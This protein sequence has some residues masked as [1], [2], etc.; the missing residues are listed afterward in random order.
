MDEPALR[1]D[2][3]S[4][5]VDETE[6]FMSQRQLPCTAL[7]KVR[8]ERGSLVVSALGMSFLVVP[9]RPESSQ[10]L[11]AR[12]WDDLVETETVGEDADRWLSE[13]LGVRCKLVHLLDGSIRPVNPAYGESGDRVGLAQCFPFLLVSEGSL[14]DLNTWLARHLPMNCLRPNLVVRGCN[15]LTEDGWRLV[16]IGPITLRVVKPCAR[17]AITTVNQRTSV[18]AKNF[19]AIWPDFAESEPRS[20]SART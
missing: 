2:C 12:V 9:P 14:T 20:S 17:C 6:R 1:H 8:I 16:R 7:I 5:L 4:M 13:F 3:R 10:L 15:P 11:L 18:K 19:C